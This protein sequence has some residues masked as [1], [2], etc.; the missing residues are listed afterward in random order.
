MK[1]FEP[2]KQFTSMT[3]TNIILVEIL[4]GIAHLSKQ[5]EEIYEESKRRTKE[6]KVHGKAYTYKE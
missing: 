5:L 1:A 4:K 3:N 6:Y 2:T